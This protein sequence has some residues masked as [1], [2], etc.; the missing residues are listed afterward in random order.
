MSGYGGGLDAGGHMPAQWRV[1]DGVPETAPP[2]PGTAGGWAWVIDR[3][4]VYH[5]VWV[6]VML[7]TLTLDGEVAR[8]TL[9][10]IDSKGRS[11]VEKVLAVD[12]PPQR[13]FMGMHGYL[14]HIAPALIGPALDKWL[15]EHP[16]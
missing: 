6:Y 7:D 10:A 13:I 8:V 4:G 11:E 5:S 15:D 2:E 1:T 14:G 16:S 9:D 3:D 12:E